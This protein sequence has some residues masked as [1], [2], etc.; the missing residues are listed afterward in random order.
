MTKNTNI[1]MDCLSLLIIIIINCDILLKTCSSAERDRKTGAKDP[2]DDR[3]R[4]ERTWSP[5]KS[6]MDSLYDT[7]TRILLFRRVITGSGPPPTQVEQFKAE[8]NEQ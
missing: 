7:R 6:R 4:M 5:T 3:G 8:L 1:G 2:F